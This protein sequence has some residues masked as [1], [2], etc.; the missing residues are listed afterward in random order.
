MKQQQSRAASVAAFV[1]CA[2]ALAAQRQA[3]A[4]AAGEEPLESIQVTATREP[5]PVDRVPA[6]ISVVTGEEL[7]SRGANDLRTAL[8]MVA[9]VEGTPG[10]DAGPAGAVP[11]LWGLREADAFLL[12]VDGIPWGGAFNPAMPSIDLENVERIEILRG[13]APVMFG[14]TS[15]VGVIHIIHYAAGASPARVTISGGSHGSYGAAGALNLP[16]IG[17]YSQSLLLSAGKHGYQEDRS[18]Y[19]RVHGLYRGAGSVGGAALHV[20]A[21][22]SVLPQRPPGNLLLRDG[23]TLHTELPIDA[24]YNPAGAKLDQQ[25]YQL[26]VRLDGD[27]ALGAWSTSVAV[28]RTF[29]DILRGFLRGEAFTAPPDGG[30][31]DG[32]Q[33]DGYTQTRGITDIYFD[34]HVTANASAALNLTYGVD[35]LRGSGSEHAINFGYC[36]DPAGN[37]LSCDGAHHADEIVSSDDQRDFAG[38]YAQADWKLAPNVDVLAG[39]RLNHTRETA[40]GLAIDNT[41][42]AP[43]V[44]FEGS[45]KLTKTRLSGLVGISWRAWAEHGNALTWYADYRNSFK[46]LAIDFGP[47]AEVEILKPETANSYEAGAKLQLLDGRLDADASV[48]RMDFSNGLTYADDGNGNFGPV[49]GGEM[50]F[51]GFEVEARYRLNPQLQLAAHYANHDARFVHFTRDNGADASGNRLEM[52]PRQVAGAG[53]VYQGAQAFG[54]SLIANYA[55]SRMLNK[56]NSVQAG[57]YTTLDGTISFQAQRY[58]LQFAAYNLTDRRDVVA[59]SELQAAVTV[60]GTSG[61]YRLPARSYA[62]SCSYEL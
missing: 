31:G 26:A 49:N 5:E 28:T 54:G 42:A 12:V 46:P 50:R 10:G 1:S 36:L 16:G 6:S 3:Q 61:Y 20:D 37:E 23:T 58:R 14:A 39:L 47:E 29:D 57:G 24:N 17:D 56:S 4:A 32:L 30:V 55:S 7:R 59:E 18:R 35:Y 9:G 62:L 2:L 48:F 41:G 19:S 25:R 40:H 44:A 27:S 34:A 21:D 45:D 22:V 52:S 33:A 11:A 13:A 43:V 51:Q 38:L 15:F 8:S 60:T 53:L